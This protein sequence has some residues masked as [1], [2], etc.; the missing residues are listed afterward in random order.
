MVRWYRLHLIS[1]T[2]LQNCVITDGKDL[3]EA[4]GC[5]CVFV[6]ASDMYCVKSYVAVL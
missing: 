6:Y 5:L 4:Q 2:L 3:P 1:V